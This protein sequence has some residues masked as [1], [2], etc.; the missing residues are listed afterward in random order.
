MKRIVAMVL[1]IGIAAAAFA[2]GNSEQPVGRGGGYGQGRGAGY[3][4]TDGAG[5]QE[6]ISILIA[7]V[8]PSD[9][10]AEEAA[11]LLFMY[12]EEKLARDVYARL[13]EIWNLPVFANISA[14][15]EQHMSAVA[16]L[17]DRYQVENAAATLAVG[18]FDDA[19][20]SELYDKLVA[21]GSASVAAA[22]RVGATIEDL[23]IADLAEYID[24][25]DNDDVRIVYQNL[26]KGSRNHIRSFVAQLDR[27]GASYDAQFIE[28]SYLEEILAI[29]REVAPITD[30][31]YVM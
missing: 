11:G 18:A 28:H 23:D 1:M 29:S 22:L 3:G 17:L 8:A 25:S 21:E 4:V 24:A 13:Y 26:M 27:V 30:P 20:L 15:E 6:D 2:G 16:Y 14:S 12:E 9:L 19:E 5:G 7:D 31:L 10:S